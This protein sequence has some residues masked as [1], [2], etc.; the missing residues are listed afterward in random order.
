VSVDDE[1]YGQNISLLPAA[2]EA[3]P[4]VKLWISFHHLRSGGC[5]G[6]LE[7]VEVSW[8]VAPPVSE[9]LAVLRASAGPAVG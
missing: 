8:A 2:Y 3:P 7:T 4:A 6:G 1:N 5:S 9:V